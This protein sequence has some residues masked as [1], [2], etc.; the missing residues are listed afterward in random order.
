M[1]LKAL[2]PMLWTTDI[3]STIDFYQNNL[4][5]QLDNYSE[6]WGWCSMHKDAVN[7]MFSLPNEHLPFEKSLCTGSFY[8]HVDDVNEI[9]EKLKEASFIFYPLEDFEYGMREFAILDNNGYILQFGQE[10]GQ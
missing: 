5:F 6:E 4:G 8:F 2:T 9:W 1:Q 3:K 10:L 7:I